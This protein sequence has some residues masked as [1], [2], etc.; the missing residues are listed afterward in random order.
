MKMSDVK[1]I[2][3][4][5]VLVAAPPASAQS[6]GAPQG[7]EGIKVVGHW[8]IVVRDE[9]GKEVQRSEFQNALTQGPGSG[10]LASLLSRG[11]TLGQWAISLTNGGPGGQPCGTATA[12][13]SCG[14]AEQITAQLPFQ[15]TSVAYVAGLT[16]GQDPADGT[17]MQLAGSM[18][19]TNSGIVTT[20]T[21]LVGLCPAG[22]PSPTGCATTQDYF[23][24]SEKYNF[25]NPP[26]VSAGQTIDV[27]V[28][29][30]FQ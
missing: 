30:S 29:F 26:T 16:V 6:S 14:L 28:T 1:W 11:R 22:P 23:R 5:L 13:R 7:P 24:F 10:S 27:T 21:S 25:A 15:N 2:V 17:K 12:G 3:V 19:A 9:A 4:A 20:V 18:R 8:T